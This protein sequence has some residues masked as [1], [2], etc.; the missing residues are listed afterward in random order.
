MPDPV[1]QIIDSLFE[2]ASV[3]SVAAPLA[4]SFACAY[5][6]GDWTV[7]RLEASV[8]GF[9]ASASSATGEPA[10]HAAARRAL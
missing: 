7:E 9:V 10:S 4:N 3:D 6:D 5:R 2:R 8:R 1:S